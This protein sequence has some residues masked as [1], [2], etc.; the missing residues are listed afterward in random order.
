MQAALI[1]ALSAHPFS[2]ARAEAAAKAL[3]ASSP[4]PA[5]V[6]LPAWRALLGVPPALDEAEESSFISAVA[7]SVAVPNA[8]VV[9]RDAARTRAELPA[10]RAA[11]VEARVARLCSYYAA[12]GYVARTA[13]ELAAALSSLPPAVQYRQGLNEVVA[14]VLLAAP[15]AAGGAEGGDL[16]T[17]LS[18]GLAMAVLSRLLAVYAPRLYGAKPDPELLS[19]QCA[20]QLFRL[21]L[22]Y[23]DP[24]LSMFLESFVCTPE[25]YATSW[26]FTL[27]LRGNTP[28]VCLALCV[29]L[30]P[31][32][33]FHM[34]TASTLL[35][36]HPAPPPPPPP[37]PSG[38]T[39][40][41]LARACPAPASFFAWPCLSF[42]PTALSS[43]Q[44]P[45][46]ARPPRSCP[47]RWR[48]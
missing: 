41:P 37:R 6:R 25:L 19:L 48:S 44:P 38:S 22:Q 30:P 47:A 40:S 43:S 46:R 32:P 28:E 2:S 4:L 5:D 45:R 16:A 20:L 42:A 1:S 10:F 15:G 39:S 29:S 13:A 36:T 12:G 26:L 9:L 21:V 18:D 8:R 24:F 17:G 34:H 7:A 27:M 14:A 35:T 23:H 11:G 3:L 33:L 31:P